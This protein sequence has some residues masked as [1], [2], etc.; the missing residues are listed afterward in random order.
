VPGPKERACRLAFAGGT[1]PLL[2]CSLE[3]A[4]AKKLGHVVTRGELSRAKHL[5]DIHAVSKVAGARLDA[6]LL[7]EALT[8]EVEHDGTLDRLPGV[9]DAIEGLRR[10]DDAT[11]RWGRFKRQAYYAGDASWQ[12]VLDSVEALLQAAIP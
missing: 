7:G 11:L 3:T 9:L 12:D 10:S 4:L 2:S 5:Y 8:A 1:A 6:A